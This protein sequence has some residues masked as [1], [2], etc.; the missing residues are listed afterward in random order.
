MKDTKG[1]IVCLASK[2]VYMSHVHICVQYI[3]VH[4]DVCCECVVPTCSRLKVLMILDG[5]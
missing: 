1:D 2:F 3:D 4:V 5:I